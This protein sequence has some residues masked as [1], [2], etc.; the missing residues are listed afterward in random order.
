MGIYGGLWLLAGEAPGR[1]WC[2]K[3]NPKE[4]VVSAVRA[5]AAA[6][7]CSQ[8]PGAEPCCGSLAVLAGDTARGGLGSLLFG[9]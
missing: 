8:A 7:K 9:V 1:E 3:Q 6:G 5:G 4:E 2:L